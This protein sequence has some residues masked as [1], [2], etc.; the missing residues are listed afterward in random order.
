[1]LLATP[2]QKQHLFRANHSQKKN[3]QV[4]VTMGFLLQ[5]SLDM[6]KVN[7]W[8]RCGPNFKKGEALPKSGGIIIDD[9]NNCRS[10]ENGDNRTTGGVRMKMK[11]GQILVGDKLINYLSSGPRSTMAYGGKVCCK[12]FLLHSRPLSHCWA[13]SR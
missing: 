10:M 4:T 5:S 9:S 6:S 13:I 12:L 1:M 11:E 8:F 3:N 2:T 7:S